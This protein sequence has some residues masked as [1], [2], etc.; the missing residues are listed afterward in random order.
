MCSLH[1]E[2]LNQE[3]IEDE[4]SKRNYAVNGQERMMGLLGCL[5][6]LMHL[7]NAWRRFEISLKESRKP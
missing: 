5:R 6:K 1:I 2:I 7:K 3:K 4:G